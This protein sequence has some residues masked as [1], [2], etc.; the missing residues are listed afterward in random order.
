M[1]S[2]DFI[3]VSSF[4][5]P[6]PYLS[7]SGGLVFP[8][9]PSIH[10]PLFATP[11]PPPL[12]LS[13]FFRTFLLFASL[14][15]L[16]GFVLAHEGVKV[17]SLATTAE[18]VCSS[19]GGGGAAALAHSE[20]EGVVDGACVIS[21]SLSHLISSHLISSHLISSHLFSNRLACPSV[22]WFSLARCGTLGPA[23][24]NPRPFRHRH[25]WYTLS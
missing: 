7:I 5:F 14:R 17:L 22:Y 11:P 13:F 9:V 12:F 16:M 10:R 25:P 20:R 19:G 18:T 8:S 6:L 3:T 1:P 21:L 4:V 15:F 23:E 24:R 2:Y